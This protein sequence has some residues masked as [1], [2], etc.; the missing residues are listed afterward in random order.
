MKGR[1][2]F[3]CTQARKGENRT[4]SIWDLASRSPWSAAIR[5]R[6]LTVWRRAH[7]EKTSETV[8]ITRVSLSRWHASRR[9]TARRKKLTRV[10][11][12]ISGPQHRVTRPRGPFRVGDG[13]PTLEGVEEDVKAGRDVHLARARVGVERVDDT[14]QGA[15]GARGDARLGAQVREVGDG[16]AGGLARGKWI[17]NFWSPFSFCRQITVAALS[18][19]IRYRR[20]WARRSEAARSCRWACPC[21]SGR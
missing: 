8:V 4:Y 13:G 1:L 2:R 12:L 16:G 20:W 17:R 14:Q 11:T 19:R 3:C 6:Y 21:R 5:G 15:E 9:L 7:S 10:R 18:P